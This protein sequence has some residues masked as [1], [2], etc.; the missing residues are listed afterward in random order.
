MSAEADTCPTQDANWDEASQHHIVDEAKRPWGRLVSTAVQLPTVDLTEK[1]V[2]IGRKS[3]C[4]IR[5]NHAAVSG[6]HCRILKVSDE[7]IFLE[8]L[9]S[10]G[11][12]VENKK[13]GNGKRILLKHGSEITLIR[14]NPALGHE[15]ISFL[16]YLMSNPP[17][18]SVPESKYDIREELGN[19]AFA[20]VKRC[21]DRQTGKHFAMKIIDKKKFKTH[22]VT[23]RSDALMDEVS[24]L[25]RIDH[26][27]VIKVFEVYQSDKYVY[28]ILE[29]TEG[30]DLFDQIVSIAQNGYPEDQARDYVRQISDALDYLHN[31]KIVH[32]D[33][34]PENILISSRTQNILKLTDFGL[35]RIID[36]GSYM[37]TLCGTPQ[38][39]APEVL[40]SEADSKKGYDKAVDLWSLGCLLYILLSG[41]PPFGDDAAAMDRI[42]QGVV[43]FPDKRWK[44]VSETGR[45]LVKRLLCVKPEL[46]ATVEDIRN[47]PW[48][49]GEKKMPPKDS[50][51]SM[52]PPRP[53]AGPA[54]AAAGR[55]QKRPLPEARA[56]V[57]VPV[58][59]PAASS[60]A[61]A[62]D[63]AS[64]AH[65]SGA[66]PPGAVLED[67]DLFSDAR[68]KRAKHA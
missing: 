12:F 7:D 29:L 65:R 41:A 58:S 9:S 67:S 62:T 21:V 35:S 38:Y 2:T 61:A 13:V 3:S 54:A 64:K 11:T 66:P 52:A 49:K 32:R 53:S 26:P 57:P 45:D 59:A 27:N 55:A 37:Q 31:N 43:E 24:I 33:L 15:K 17:S 23:K 25:R 34:K 68:T 50:A 4:Q 30:G 36:E 46:R 56:A 5:V 60:A 14:Q 16:I 40:T 6:E 63:G 42:K 22:Q 1:S 18:Q 19:G 48:M 47:H 20:I 10:N 51:G 8:D 44:H 28:L 39:L